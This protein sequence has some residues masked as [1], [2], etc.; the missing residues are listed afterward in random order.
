[1]T[2]QRE[3]TPEFVE[4]IPEQLD[5]GVIY[6]SMQYATAVHRCCCG[7]GREV[8]TP[9]TPTDWELTFNGESV[10]L[11]P[12]IGNWSFPCQSHYWI[13]RGKVRWAPKWTRKQVEA[14]RSKDRRRKL[15]RYD[16]AEAPY[17]PGLEEGPTGSWWR[18]LLARLNP[19]RQ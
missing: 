18:R 2:R 10:S 12:S 15:A 8:V 16:E 19:K 14:G 17:D 9:F 7:C 4:T 3:L 1:M 13:T 6:I 5:D 11:T